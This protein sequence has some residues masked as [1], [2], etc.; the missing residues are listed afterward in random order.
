VFFQ[1]QDKSEL[2]GEQPHDGT[3]AHPDQIRDTDK[4]RLPEMLEEILTRERLNL[5]SKLLPFCML[6]VNTINGTHVIDWSIGN[7]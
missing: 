3:T 7:D 2:G 4:H 6:K 1:I 5:M